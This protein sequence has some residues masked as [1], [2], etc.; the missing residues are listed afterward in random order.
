MVRI[1]FTTRPGTGDW[2]WRLELICEKGVPYITML[3][4]CALK[5]DFYI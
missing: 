4:Y 2:G 1:E 5:A 3:L